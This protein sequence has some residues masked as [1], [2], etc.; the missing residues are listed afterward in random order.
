M[1]K[2]FVLI[3][4][5]I[6]SNALSMA[7]DVAEVPDKVYFFTKSKKDLIYEFT[8]DKNISDQIKIYK[9]KS[10]NPLITPEELKN[11]NQIIIKIG[12]KDKPRETRYD[13]DISELTL[14]TFPKL[15]ILNVNQ[16]QE[17]K[18]LIN[19]PYPCFIKNIVASTNA[20]RNELIE[21][22]NA[23][24]AQAKLAALTST[25]PAIE[26]HQE[27]QPMPIIVPQQQAVTQPVI[28]QPITEQSKEPTLSYWQRWQNWIQQNKA[29]LAIT[30]TAAVGISTGAYYLWRNP[31]RFNQLKAW[32]NW[33]KK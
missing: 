5:I 20:I 27:V 15:T 7:A 32:F 2:L 31:E 8:S 28:A 29:R 11:V 4:L 12:T 17:V 14:P 6:T 18:N 21:Q 23:A 24:D 3:I 33:Y 26:P 9:I 1:K 30:G 25:Q 16:A 22:L 19:I 13:I 10:N